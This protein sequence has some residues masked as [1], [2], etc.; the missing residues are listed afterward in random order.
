MR[1]KRRQKFLNK[2]FAILILVV[3]T[4]APLSSFA[5][6]AAPN[7]PKTPGDCWSKSDCMAKVGDCTACFEE[8]V[9]LCG[10]GRGFCY[11]EPVP[12]TLS[13]NLGGLHIVHDPAQYISKL[14][15]WGISATGILAAI[16]IMIGGLLYLTAGGSQERVS[17]AKSYISNALIGLFLAMTSY[18]LL[19][20]INPSLLTLKFPKIKMP[21]PA[22]QYAQFCEEIIRDNPDIKV[23]PEVPGK[24]MCGDLGIP[25]TTSATTEIPSKCVYGTTQ[26]EENGCQ[27]CLDP[28]PAAC[29][30]R[31][32]EMPCAGVRLDAALTKIG[33]HGESDF[34]VARRQF[35]Q[36]TCAHLAPMPRGA[37]IFGCE[38]GATPKLLSGGNVWESFKEFAGGVASGTMTIVFLAVG[39]KW[40]YR[41]TI[42]EQ[43]GSI[44]EIGGALTGRQTIS[45]TGATVSQAAGLTSDTLVVAKS[46]IKAAAAPAVIPLVVMGGATIAALSEFFKVAAAS[47]EPQKFF[48]T[49]GV[50]A[51]VRVDCD[52]INNCEDYDKKIKFKGEKT[53]SMREIIY[54]SITNPIES[55]ATDD[56][57]FAKYCNNNPCQL[58]IKCR[59][60]QQKYYY[61][62]PSGGRP[63]PLPEN[64]TD[65]LG[66]GTLGLPAEEDIKCVNLQMN[67]IAGDVNESGRQVYRYFKDDGLTLDEIYPIVY[68]FSYLY[69][70]KKQQRG[71]LCLE[72]SD[73]APGLT[74]SMP[75][76]TYKQVK[77]WRGNIYQT[78]HNT[79]PED[80]TFKRCN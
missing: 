54:D 77:R 29:P 45:N 42:V 24:T 51:L 12:L 53:L 40:I 38:F 21:P 22:A 13:I 59:I 55:I 35:G 74:C 19:Q 61:W 20:T 66:G 49:Q 8:N 3:L 33:A 80:I 67:A 44:A 25:Q 43:A 72:D 39:G 65:A 41:T 9:E 71:Q 23:T 63:D 16:M 17:N 18:L 14:Y 70:G 5:Q 1:F 52:Q 46:A 58:P 31:A 37:A 57:D 73:C 69:P 64:S 27:L 75:G 68:P 50:C 56:A 60:T 30:Q 32:R 34:V 78:L 11:A 76:V 2:I 7:V 36:Q 10:T 4:I 28:D 62:S 48:A 47:R 79:R 6:P 15:E 26:N